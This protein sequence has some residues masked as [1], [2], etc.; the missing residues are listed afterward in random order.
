MSQQHDMLNGPIMLVMLFVWVCG[1]LLVFPFTV[2][3]EDDVP[4]TNTLALLVPF[5]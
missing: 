3:D 2:G 1:L 4:L 5:T